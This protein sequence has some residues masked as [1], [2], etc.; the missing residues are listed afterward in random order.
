MGSTLIKISLLNFLTCSLTLGFNGHA[1]ATTPVEATHDFARD[2]VFS[3][4]SNPLLGEPEKLNFSDR[5][6]GSMEKV[7]SRQV[8]PAQQ[9]I[10]NFPWPPQSPSAAVDDQDRGRSQ[11]VLSTSEGAIVD[12]NSGDVIAQQ[13][14][15]DSEELDVPSEPDPAAPTFPGT[16]TG[17][18]LNPSDNLLELP[19]SPDVIRVDKVIPLTL[20][21]AISLAETNNRPLQI[22]RTQLRRDQALVDQARAQ[23][24]PTLSLQG[25]VSRQLDPS[26][27]ISTNA[28][29]D[30][31]TSQIAETTSAINTIQNTLPTVT[32]PVEVVVLSLQLSQ[33]QQNLQSSQIALNQLDSYA[34]TNLSGGLQVNYALYSP[35]RTASIQQAEA[36]TEFTALEVNRLQQEV[37]LQVTNAYYDLQDAE[38]QAEIFRADIERRS[39]SLRD[40]EALLGAGLA[41]RLDLLNSQ[42]ELDASQQNLINAESQV[43]SAQS[44]L[45][46][47]LST[48]LGLT[49]TTA[50]P[51]ATVDPWQL[52]LEETIFLALQNRAE[53]DQQLAQRQAAEAQRQA[54]LAGTRPQVNL[55][56][57]YDLLQLY[58]DD[59]RGSAVE[60]FG[61]GYSLGLTVN[62]LIL[63][64]GA[65]NAGARAAEANIEV[66][67]LQFS[68][69]SNQ[70][71]SEITQA[72][73]SLLANTEN[74]ETAENAVS[75]AEEALRI[76]R[77]RFQAG[78]GTQSDVLDAEF[79][80]TQALGN[81]TTA[82]LGY[83]RSIAALQRFIGISASQPEAEPE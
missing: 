36:Q 60:G 2:A 22:A 62:W 76:A 47:I 8:P 6:I 21:Q 40:I 18:N 53:L 63:D 30:Q 24:F 69:T 80:L 43:E 29:R 70:I 3:S 57:T 71:R 66:A 52:S 31:L 48:P 11:T 25:Q 67:D 7:E 41:T 65:A 4:T 74:L 23:L 54:A 10:Q 28:T 33:L 68:E 14:P 1:R 73:A 9:R 44:T 50:E 35:Q 51:V 12:S 13:S 32:D 16:D 26:T 5:S 38:S 77:L 49:I 19:D 82:V 72:Y 37:R 58:T 39:R 64:G 17:V 15:I 81:V 83:N 20:E 78:V 42:V 56:A 75:R 27:E 55:F 46:Q 61:D 59:P 79:R 45:V 34:T